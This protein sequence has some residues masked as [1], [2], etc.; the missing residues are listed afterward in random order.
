MRGLIFW[1]TP[2]MRTGFEPGTANVDFN[3]PMRAALAKLRDGERARLLVSKAGFELAAKSGDAFERRVALPVRWIKGFVEVQAHQARMERRFAISG[4]IAQRFLRDLPRQRT[5]GM[6]FVSPMGNTLRLS[7]TAAGGGVPV[8]GIDRLRILADVARHAVELEVYSSGDGA[9]AWRMETLDTRLFVVLSPEPS[10]GFSGEGQVLGAL[11]EGSSITAR[12]RAML[13]WQSSLDPRSLAAELDASETEIAAA[14]AELGTAGLVGYDL[15]EARYFHR[16][17]P[18]DLARVAK[19]HPRLV[20]ARELVRTGQVEIEAAD[21]K[22]VGARKGRRV[23]REARC[24]RRLALP[25]PVGRKARRLARALQA[26]SRCPDRFGRN[27]RLKDELLAA[28]E[29]GDEQTCVRLLK[30]QDE[31]ARRKLYPAVAEK[32]EE[33]DAAFKSDFGPT[34][35]EIFRRHTAAQLAMLGTAMLGEL[36]KTALWQFHGEAAHAVLTE[37]RP[38]W[39]AEWAQ[40]E[41]EK[42]FR[43]WAARACAGSRWTDSQASLRLLHSRHDRGA[44]PPPPAAPVYRTGSRFARRRTLALV[45]V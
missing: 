6:T 16:E 27:R 4:A 43:N 42:N 8:G 21:G 2:L 11:A 33:I 9:T 29:A 22:R 31:R 28:I 26:Y 39:L 45:R 13:R 24:R 23:S 38:S 12:L 36:K 19:V 25:L 5:P 37:R 30:G 41:L 10:R 40:F 17:L 14:L 35:P 7:Q 44:R 32:I 1:A 20:A 15:A 34:R 3:P 18:F